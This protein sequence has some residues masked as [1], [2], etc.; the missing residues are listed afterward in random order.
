MLR[1]SKRIQGKDYCTSILKQDDGM[2]TRFF[3]A[4]HRANELGW[5]R[6]AVVVSKKLAKLAVDRNRLR[7]QLYEA[8]QR[9]EEEISPS[10]QGFDIILL[11]RSSLLSAPFD[12]QLKA[13]KEVLTHI[14]GQ[15]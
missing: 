3:G 5:N 11:T 2:K 10:A 7:R 15:N 9:A 12:V 13:V 14:H 8:I 1:R 6:F 4:K